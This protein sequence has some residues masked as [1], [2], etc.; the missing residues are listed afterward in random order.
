MT[1][2]V[3]KTY[4]KTIVLTLDASGIKDSKKVAIQGK[5]KPLSWAYDT[6]MKEIK[7]DNLYQITLTGETD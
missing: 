7:K 4:R 6:E 3:Q 5:D 2:C 1:S